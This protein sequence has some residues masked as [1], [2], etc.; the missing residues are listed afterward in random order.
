MLDIK[1]KEAVTISTHVR[2]R[3]RAMHGV[4]VSPLTCAFP[5]YRIADDH[6]G[7]VAVARQRMH[8]DGVAASSHFVHARA[9]Q[10]SGVELVLQ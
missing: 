9:A 3:V 6:C 4:C 8:F 10:E 5:I 2:R 1:R 7:V